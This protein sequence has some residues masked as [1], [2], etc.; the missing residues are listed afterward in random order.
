MPELECIKCSR[1]MHYDELNPRCSKC[2]GELIPAII[3]AKLSWDLF[4]SRPPGVWRYREFLPDPRSEKVTLGEG[5]TPL[6]HAKRVGERLGLKQLLIKDETRNPTGSFFDRGSTVF[7]SIAKSI[8]VRRIKCT[9]TG[10]LGASLSAYAAKAG[11]EAEISILPNVDIGKLYQML[12]YGAKVEVVNEDKGISINDIEID[13]SNPFLLYGEKTT[14]YEIIQDLGWEKPD[15]IILPVG[16]GGH[17]TMIWRAIRELENAG[18]VSDGKCRMI[19]VQAEAQGPRWTGG[20]SYLSISELEESK[21]VFIDN[22]LKAIRESGG[23]ILRVSVD[24]AVRAMAELARYEGIFAEPASASVISALFKVSNTGLL[25][26]DDRV[27]AIITGSGLK[28]ARMITK[29]ARVPRGAARFEPEL[30]PIKLGR[31]KAK[32]ME[33]LRNGPLFGY[34][35]WKGLLRY[36]SITIPSVYQHLSELERYSLIRK[37]GVSMEK[38]RQRV[39]YELTRKGIEFLELIERSGV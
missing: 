21:P 35:I 15:V 12:A 17:L 37:Y 34:S 28:E 7:V 25:N 38:N 4:E 6:L 27:V 22:A 16:T 19:G 33:L 26:S 31:T 29:V 36:R 11:I 1:I 23:A 9:T 24:E 18:L 8:N 5:A 30:T 3:R 2:G 39:Y 20:S 14:G 10:N 13:A 32:I